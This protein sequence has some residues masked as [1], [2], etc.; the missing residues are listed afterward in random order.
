MWCYIGQTK[1]RLL[2]G[3]PA[4]GLTKRTKESIEKDYTGIC[5]CI[6]HVGR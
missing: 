1:I 3:D 4:H 5:I 2:I 6:H